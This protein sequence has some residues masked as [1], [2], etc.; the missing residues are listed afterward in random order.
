MKKSIAIILAFLFLSVSVFAQSRL[1]LVPC[2]S[3]LQTDQYPVVNDI[4]EKQIDEIF[5]CK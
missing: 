1:I 5:A 2:C 4:L 3:M